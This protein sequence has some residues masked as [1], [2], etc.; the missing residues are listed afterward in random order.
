[1]VLCPFLPGRQFTDSDTL[2]SLLIDTA[3]L[4]NLWEHLQTLVSE[5][6]L[7]EIQMH[8]LDSRGRD[9]REDKLRLVDI[10]VSE[11]FAQEQRDSERPWR[12]DMKRRPEEE[13]GVSE[14]AKK[15]ALSMQARLAKERERRET[16]AATRAKKRVEEQRQEQEREAKEVIELLAEMNRRREAESVL[17]AQSHRPALSLQARLARDREHREK[18]ATVHRE[19]IQRETRLAEEREAEEILKWYASQ[20]LRHWQ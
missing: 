13:S 17:S 5:D 8:L 11:L 10:Y 16:Q 12:S 19:N 1:M 20:A 2:K 15:S 18:Q 14:Q 3:N 6:R 4:H 9:V 7:L